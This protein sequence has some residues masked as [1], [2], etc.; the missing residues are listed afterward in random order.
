MKRVVWT[1]GLTVGLL[2][3]GTVGQARQM[4]VNGT[5]ENGN[6]SGWTEMNPRY[7]NAP[8]TVFTGM[9]D[10]D[11][12]VMT[13]YAGNY[14]CGW[15]RSDGA[16][17][18]PI[19]GSDSTQPCNSISQTWSIS[20]GSYPIRV[21]A[22]VFVHHNRQEMPE[23]RWGCGLQMAIYVD[24][25]FTP[26]WR[27]TFWPHQGDSFWGYFDEIDNEIE[28]RI[29]NNTITTNQ[30][31]VRFV[32][33]W[34]SKW[35]IDLD[36]SAVDNVEVDIIGANLLNGPVADPPLVAPPVPA[37]PLVPQL[38]AGIP[39]VLIS[40]YNV[41][42]GLNPTWAA[43][44]DVNKDGKRDIVT[45]NEWS[46]TISVLLGNGDGT[47]GAPTHISV[48]HNPRCVLAVDANNDTNLDLIV[49]NKA[50]HN[51][52]VLRGNG[53]G[54]FQSPL[55]VSTGK[56][57][58]KISYGRFNADNNVDLAVPEESDDTMSIYLGNGNGTFSRF[59]TIAV[60]GL[61][62]H[63]L[64]DD[65][66]S[67]G[68]DD[69]LVTRFWNGDVRC[70]RGQGN[71]TFTLS[72]TLSSG[73]QTTWSAVA[74]FN[75]DGRKDVIATTT[76]P[77]FDA[78]SIFLGSGNA[79]FT[80]AD[81]FAVGLPTSIAT[82]DLNGDNKAD[83]A[84]SDFGENDIHLA[85]GS[86]IPD[87]SAFTVSRI[88]IGDTG[89]YVTT[90][91]MNNDTVPDFIVTSGDSNTVSIALGRAD[92][93][94]VAPLAYGISGNPAG[95]DAGDV[96]GDRDLE[97]FVAADEGGSG[98]DMINIYR[99]DG[100]MKMLRAQQ[101]SVGSGFLPA[102][103]SAQDLNGDRFAD[104]VVVKGSASQLHVYRGLGNFS[105]QGPTAYNC[106]SRPYDLVVADF[107]GDLVPDLATAN[108][109]GNSVSV[110]L[111][112]GNTNFAS[113]QTYNVGLA[114]EALA[115]GFFNNDAFL[116][117]AVANSLS[118]TVSILLNQGNGSFAAAGTV[119]VGTLPRGIAALDL[120]GDGRDDLVVSN[121]S[122][123]N[124]SILL[125]N[126]SGG[127]PTRTNLATGKAPLRV[128]AAD[129]NR[130]GRKD[131]VVGNY[132]SGTVWILLSNG[133][134]TFRTPEV[135]TAARGPLRLVAGDLW[136][137]GV[138]DLALGTD[139]PGRWTLYS[140]A[141]RLPDMDGDELPD[142]LEARVPAAGQTNMMLPDSDGDGLADGVEDANRNGNRD[143][144]ETSARNADSDGDRIE[145]GVE[146]KGIAPSNPLD[147]ASPLGFI[148]GDGDGL[149]VFDDPNDSD[150]DSDDDRY[151][152]RYEFVTLGSAAPN[153]ASI[154]PRLGDLNLD[155]FITS[156][157]A[158]IAQ[159][160][161]LMLA[162][163]ED[164]VFHPGGVEI[165][166][167]VNGDPTRDGY[168]TSLDA[169][170]IQSYF[171]QL[172]DLLPL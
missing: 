88:P 107:S 60:G 137:R 150:Q 49:A 59:T 115:A 19:P 73:W 132:G 70:Y 172:R 90:G 105:F 99:N 136:N 66:N 31:T 120:N 128:V 123:N 11:Y 56:A 121:H 47:V 67:D 61:P 82:F 171:L 44:A 141:G 100:S 144:G 153:N 5:F 154:K 146:V 83:F 149:G 84:T 30:G 36:A 98:P 42:V 131:I 72:S 112:T 139:N 142:S 23:D 125:N 117:L 156:L 51:L 122:D 103:V 22:A 24:N 151:G 68:R 46:H 138:P 27:H 170:L 55:F 48:G 126:G 75:N 15:K 102:A 13:H 89:R 3:V 159:S 111:G 157:D 28:G 87:I 166:G 71:G 39:G 63:S 43:V 8:T 20:P 110:L 18:W 116:D 52:T 7:P 25:S 9:F 40:A 93:T 95:M 118:N 34:I 77:E 74:D 106:G 17:Y 143:A 35:T 160:L 109:Q 21:S 148:D 152:D 29:G 69:I 4:V 16:W 64:V 10:P 147:P 76:W 155:T 85:L 41:V 37:A 108:R 168:V 165:G 2:G 79:T 81:S 130:D 50:D 86:G 162:N 161:F 129:Y 167:Y 54:T 134:G 65:F 127:F 33:E 163:P 145:D 53:N 97:L 38:T 101:I 135:Y 45:A 94:V 6:F 158:L 57:P 92:G 32:I 133:N 1:V 124:I 164:A 104:L 78:T 119:N 169:L 14:S 91:D 26:T 96:D 140:N 113:P 58:G 62:S 12:P 114:P 80:L